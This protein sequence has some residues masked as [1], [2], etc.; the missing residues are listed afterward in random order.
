MKLVI[1]VTI[2]LAIHATP[3]SQAQAPPEATGAGRPVFEA[4]SIKRNVTVSD[5]ASVRTQPGGRL[6]VNNNSLRNIV[7]NAYNVQNFQIVGGPDWINTDRWDIVAKAE[8]DVPPPQLL[9]MVRNLL[10]DRFK[11]V[12]HTEMRETAV[13][14]L[15][16][17]RSDGRLGPQ[18]RPSTVDCAALMASFQA[19]KE[20]PPNTINGRPACG[21]RVTAGNMM[22]TSTRMADLARNLAPMA[23]RPIVD[24]TGLTGTYDIDLTW[25]PDPQGAPGTAPAPD[26]DRPSLVTAV[27]EQLGLKL[28]SQRVPFETLVIDSVERPTE[29]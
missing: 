2:A 14:A 16:L 5:Q 3:Y 29:D 21:T 4:A 23:G 19:R 24:R 26:G 12:V 7:R 9:I 13:Y 20:T 15:V 1:A 25:A 6:T 18:L 27:Q 28:E 11:L 17:T 10:A 22:T 8:S